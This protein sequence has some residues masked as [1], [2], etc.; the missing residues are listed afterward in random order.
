[1]TD[2]LERRMRSLRLSGM[3]ETLPIRNRQ[4][5]EGNLS[6]MEFLELLVGDELDRRR[7]RLLTRRLKRARLPEVKTIAD[8]NF[9][10]NPKIPRALILDM[11]TARFVAE[12]RGLLL[13]GPSGVGKSHIAI[14]LAVAAISAGHTALYRSAFDLVQDLAEASATGGRRELIGELS[15]VELLILEDLGMKS[16]PQAMAEDLTEVFFR[17]YERAST[18]V[19]TNR[20]IEDWGKVL[21]DTASAGAILDRFLHY[22]E[23]VS[24]T[25]PSYRLHSRKKS[26]IETKEG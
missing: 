4:A 17:R 26:G 2:D 25:G 12:H 15:Q 11:A 18:I 3:V 24:I 13:I 5:V 19:T 23:I 7:D 8:F 14:S 20:P 9:S 1:M 22:A 16:I 6:H 21:G 10:F